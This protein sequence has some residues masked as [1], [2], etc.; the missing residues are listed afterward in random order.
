MEHNGDGGRAAGLPYLNN[1]FIILGTALLNIVCVL[2]FHWGQSVA[3]RDVVVSAVF[4]GVCTSLINVTVTYFI[5]KRMRRTGALPSTAP[6]SRL[7]MRLPKDPVLL[8]LLFAAVFG[9]AAALFNALVIR[10]YE[11]ESFNLARF[12]VWQAAYSCVLSAVIADLAVLRFIQPDC[13]TADQ[14]PQTGLAKVHDPRA[15]FASLKS[16]FNTV[17]DDFGFNMLCGLLLG[18]TVVTA[19]HTVVIAPTTRAGIVISSL[20]LGVILTFRMAYPIA[21]NM[22]EARESGA[23]PPF[24]KRSAFFSAL[25]SKPIGMTLLLLL[26][27]MLVSLAVCWSVL[28]FFD[29]AVLNFFQFF[30]IRTIYVALLTKPVVAWM[31]ARYRQPTAAGGHTDAGPENDERKA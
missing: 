5:T 24:E 21:K 18:G 6:V 11:I 20:I 13:T 7:M 14:P 1:F 9:A 30:F 10:F 26:P 12:A 16:W 17:T 29:F 2:A 25:P 19:E 8:I 23:L 15:K 4:C 31:L 3:A 28:T 27:I 22:Y